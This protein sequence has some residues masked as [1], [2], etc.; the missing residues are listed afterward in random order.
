MLFTVCKICC[1]LF[2]AICTLRGLYMS[3]K[4]KVGDFVVLAIKQGQIALQDRYNELSQDLDNLRR[5]IILP[6]APS[7]SGSV[8]S[9]YHMTSLLEC[10]E[11]LLSNQAFVVTECR[12]RSV[13]QG[14]L[15]VSIKMLLLKYESQSW[16]PEEWLTNA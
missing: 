2:F 5:K 7:N 11:A 12:D 15:F 8:M 9:S 6:G 14:S 16:L 10:Y 13:S 4:I 1:T 3:R